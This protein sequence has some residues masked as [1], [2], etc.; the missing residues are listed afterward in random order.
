MAETRRPDI[1]AHGA[2]ADGVKR[3]DRLARNVK[4][5]Q[6]ARA[7]TGAKAPA[8]EAFERSPEDT[9]AKKYMTHCIGPVCFTVEALAEP[10]VFAKFT[11]PPEA[12]TQSGGTWAVGPQTAKN[13]PSRGR[14]A[15]EQASR[16]P[17]GLAIGKPV[18]R[19][20]WLDRLFGR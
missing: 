3:F 13:P 15:G 10:P 17:I 9:W 7:K 2:L 4:N 16:G 18:R 19:R 6:L 12:P 14:P 11:V 20:F 1:A 5:S 8:T